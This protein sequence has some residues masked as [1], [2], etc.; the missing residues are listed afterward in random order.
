M[1]GTLSK[2]PSKEETLPTL[3]ILFIQI[4]LCK[5][6][7]PCEADYFG[8]NFDKALLKA[9]LSSKLSPQSAWKFVGMVYLVSTPDKFLV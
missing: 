4:T 2:T 3:M 8:A 9:V 7:R 5:E 1:I 6:L